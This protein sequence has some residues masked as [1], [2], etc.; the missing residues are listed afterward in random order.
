MYKRGQE[1]R[2]RRPKAPDN[3]SEELYE[4][5]ADDRFETDGLL[6]LDSSL[7]IEA[8]TTPAEDH[9]GAPV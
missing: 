3:V 5:N 4:L 6:N 1:E 9:D 2:R 7:G 8:D